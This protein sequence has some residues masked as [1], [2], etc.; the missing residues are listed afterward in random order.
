MDDEEEEGKSKV[1]DR[2]ENY[3]L[4]KLILSYLKLTYFTL[5]Y[6]NWSY[7]NL[8]YFMLY[9][10]I[11]SLSIR[12]HVLV[13]SVVKHF[14]FERETSLIEGLKTKKKYSQLP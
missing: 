6:L 4:I 5:S 11:L 10:L 8:Y 1:N 3:C 13:Y 12:R 7:L 9:E 14:F 2:E